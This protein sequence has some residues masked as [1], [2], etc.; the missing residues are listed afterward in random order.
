VLQ[1]QFDFVDDEYELLVVDLVDVVAE[2]VD[3]EQAGAGFEG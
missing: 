3:A 2:V 1:G